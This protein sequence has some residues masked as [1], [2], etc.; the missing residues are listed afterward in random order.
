MESAIQKKDTD[1]DVLGRKLYEQFAIVVR[2]KL[3]T[4]GTATAHRHASDEGCQHA[5]FVSP[6]W[7]DALLGFC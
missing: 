4:S 3:N 5:D 2:L 6:P 1:K 7:R